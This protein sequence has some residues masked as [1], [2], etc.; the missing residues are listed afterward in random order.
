MYW[1][2]DSYYKGNWRDG[3]QNGDGEIYI[4]GSGYKKG[5]FENNELIIVEKALDV[6]E[7][8]N[9]F[10]REETGSQ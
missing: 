9:Y 2:D 6:P 4:V 1:S 10:K 8:N 5:I 7:S 3:V